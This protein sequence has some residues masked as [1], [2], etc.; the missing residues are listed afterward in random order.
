MSSLGSDES[1]KN[2]DHF[3]S[4]K[5]AFPYHDDAF[6]KQALLDN[7]NNLQVAFNS[8]ADSNV[9]GNHQDLEAA[10]GMLRLSTS[11]I[12][13]VDL[14]SV[15]EDTAEA[16]TTFA[17]QQEINYDSDQSIV[18]DTSS[19]CS[20]TEKTHLENDEM[21]KLVDEKNK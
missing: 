16:S 14:S 5:D 15:H 2:S 7:D 9:Q 1:S 20:S 6:L 13:V 10:Q 21:Q 8:I 12:E 19:E 4:L 11:E 17:T 3:Q 18:S